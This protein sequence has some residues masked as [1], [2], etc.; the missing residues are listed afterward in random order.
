MPLPLPPAPSTGNL[1]GTPPLVACDC[2][3][4]ELPPLPEQPLLAC[5]LPLPLP[6]FLCSVC[7]AV[8]DS[9]TAESTVIVASGRGGGGGGGAAAPAATDEAAS[10]LVR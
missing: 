2:M 1:A 9:G 7:G 8:W 4:P 6:Q 10:A 5:P 3:P